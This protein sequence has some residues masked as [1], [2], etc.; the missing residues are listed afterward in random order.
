MYLYFTQMGRCM[1]T[2]EEI[3]LSQLFNDNIYD[4][5]HIY[6]RHFVKDDN[7]D[8]NLV[9]V[10]KTVNAHKSDIYPLEASI[11][12]TQKETLPRQFDYGRKV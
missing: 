5:D 8:N 12:E 10:K 11:Y 7:L 6:P 2:G 3:E 4:I 9:L 1:Y